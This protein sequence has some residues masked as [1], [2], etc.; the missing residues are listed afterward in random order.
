VDFS[1]SPSTRPG[2]SQVFAHTRGVLAYHQDPA[3]E[4]RP[5]YLLLGGAAVAVV[6]LFLIGMLAYRTWYLE[7]IDPEK[8]YY[9]ISFLFCFYVLGVFLFCYAYELYDMPR[10]LRLTLIA[11][12]VSVVLLFLVIFALASLSKLRSGVEAVAGEG[13]SVS[14][15]GLF[16]T[17]ASYAGGSERDRR[18][19]RDWRERRRLGSFEPDNIRES[20]P[21][22]VNC[23]GCGEMFSPVPPKAECPHCGRAAISS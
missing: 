22:L 13:D 2:D 12:F 14:D 19:Q 20:V 15:G 5:L 6:C 7:E 3:H 8:A 9:G 1:G 23:L 17:I 10:A 16:G 4:G 11:A 21:F 18:Y